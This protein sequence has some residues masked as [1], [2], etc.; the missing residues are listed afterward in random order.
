M[1]PVARHGLSAHASAQRTGLNRVAKSRTSFA[2]GQ[3]GNPGGRPRALL[4]AR[5][6]AR[7]HTPEAIAALVAA[8]NSPRERV[9][10]A[11]AL[12]DRAWGKPTAF[13]AGDGD[14]PPAIIH[15]T[16][17]SA[18]PEQSA[19]EPQPSDGDAEISVRWT[20]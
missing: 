6:L 14:A 16:W 8:L 7:T 20:C 9:A 4:D 17:A 15:F 3:S 1:F 10:A 12:L 5:E 13:V 11:T 19:L 18:V 2:P